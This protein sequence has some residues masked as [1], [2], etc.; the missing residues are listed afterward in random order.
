MTCE[1]QSASSFKKTKKRG[2]SMHTLTNTWWSMHTLTVTHKTA[3]ILQQHNR[4]K[5]KQKYPNNT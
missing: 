3:K 2:K 5:E 1:P 4:A